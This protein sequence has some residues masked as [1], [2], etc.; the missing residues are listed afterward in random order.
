MKNLHRLIEEGVMDD[1]KAE[2][3]VLKPEGFD[4][5]FRVV[6]GF[7]RKVSEWATNELMGI[8]YDVVGRAAM[9]KRKLIFDRITCHHSHCFQCLGRYPLHFPYFR[10]TIVVGA[11]K[12]RRSCRAEEFLDKDELRRFNALKNLRDSTIQVSNA[13]V[14]LFEGLGMVSEEVVK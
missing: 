8:C 4:E 10:E 2:L 1:L 5:S 7:M 6:L 13:L 12:R 9:Q 3:G 11:E 14:L